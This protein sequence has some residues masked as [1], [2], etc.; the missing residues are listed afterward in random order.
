MKRPS[1]SD[2]RTDNEKN[3]SIDPGF[4]KYYEELEK[5]CNYLESLKEC[6]FAKKLK[7]FQ[8]EPFIFTQ[9]PMRQL[10]IK[11]DSVAIIELKSKIVE[12]SLQLAE[13]IAYNENYKELKLDIEFLIKIVETLK[14]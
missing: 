13:L 6:D 2:F 14:N 4:I 7:D 9:E 11:T 3:I 5:Y 1:I 12:K 10:I 8:K